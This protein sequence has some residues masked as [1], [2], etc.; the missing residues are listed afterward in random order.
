V[1]KLDEEVIEYYTDYLEGVEPIGLPKSQ[2]EG[3]LR[4][5]GTKGSKFINS[6]LQ[7]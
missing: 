1:G 3:R 5:V 2:Y 4:G 6:G 7:R